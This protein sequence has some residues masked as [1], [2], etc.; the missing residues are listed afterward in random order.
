[1]IPKKYE[2]LAQTQY[3]KGPKTQKVRPKMFYYVQ[4]PYFLS[5]L[6][7][8]ISLSDID[9]FPRTFHVESTKIVIFL[10]HFTHN[11]FLIQCPILSYRASQALIV[12]PRRVGVTIQESRDRPVG[13]PWWGPYILTL[14]LVQIFEYL[15]LKW[16]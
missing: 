16:S 1:M 3:G 11:S 6:S 5:H 4:L 7:I 15:C 10:S 8:T 9:L 14:I 13:E 12:S 2:F